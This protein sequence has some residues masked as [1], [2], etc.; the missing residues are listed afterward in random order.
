MAQFGTDANSA[1]RHGAV[2]V[3]LRNV[4]SYQI[5]GHPYITGSVIN[6]GQEMKVSFPYVTKK[7]T[8]IAS[9][10]LSGHGLRV[11]FATTGSGNNVVGGKHYIT[12]NSHEDSMEFDVKCKELYLSAPGAA[13]AGFML[14][15]SLTNIPTSSMYA[16]TGSGVTL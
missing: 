15:A 8:V 4:G 12:L 11:H 10:S 13:A 16:V 2:G 1:V 9:G 7:I 5:S 6:A 14:Y 3:G